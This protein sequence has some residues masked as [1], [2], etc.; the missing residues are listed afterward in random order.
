M[1]ELSADATENKLNLDDLGPLPV[2]EADEDAIVVA[3]QQNDQFYICA[4]MVKR[5]LALLVAEAAAVL[6]AHTSRHANFRQTGQAWSG[7]LQHFGKLDDREFQQVISDL[8]RF[9]RHS[10][11]SPQLL[12]RAHAP[13][14]IERQ[15]TGDFTGRNALQTA[16]QDSEVVQVMRRMAE[17]LCDWLDAT[18]H[19]ET[20]GQRRLVQGPT[21]FR[22]GLPI[23]AFCHPP[24]RLPADRRH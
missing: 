3:Q 19:L 9:M 12:L 6:R 24:W 14:Q 4:F 18:I 16:H 15:V 17:R 22:P 5:W 2:M 11:F 20:Y 7:F 21:A 1:A 10:G 23:A 8:T 13:L